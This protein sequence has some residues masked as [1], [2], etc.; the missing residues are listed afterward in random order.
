MPEIG[1]MLL[2]EY[3][4]YEEVEQKVRNDTTLIHN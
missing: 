2:E 1:D 4:D 3:V